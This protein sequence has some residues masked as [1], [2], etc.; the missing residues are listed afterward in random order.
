[1]LECQNAETTGE[2]LVRHPRIFTVSKMPQSGI[3]ILAKYRWSVITDWSD[4][5]AM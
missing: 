4:C 2:K 3:G 5:P 1:M